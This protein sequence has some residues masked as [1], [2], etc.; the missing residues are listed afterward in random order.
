[1]PSTSLITISAIVISLPPLKGNVQEIL[2]FYPII[3]MVGG[4]GYEGLD[5]ANI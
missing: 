1:M 5:A 3:T 4:F 2:A